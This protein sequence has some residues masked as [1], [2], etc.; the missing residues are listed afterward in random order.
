[1][2]ETDRQ[3]ARDAITVEIVFALLTGILLT[4]LTFLVFSAPVLLHLVHGR[5]RSVWLTTA[6]TAGVSVGVLRTVGVL[7]RYDR[8][9]PRPPAHH[10]TPDDRA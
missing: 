5:T 3:A 7:R 1:V 2:G 4:G 10:G 6:I 8:D 9:H